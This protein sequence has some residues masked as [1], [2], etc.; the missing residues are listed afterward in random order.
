MKEEAFAR[1]RLPEPVRLFERRASRFSALAER[2]A[3][4]EWLLLLSRIASGQALAAREV[5]LA[6]GDA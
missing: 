5:R 4:P 1:V 2:H 3:A 6:G